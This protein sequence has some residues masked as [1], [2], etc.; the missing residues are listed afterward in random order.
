MSRRHASR[1]RE[2]E[3]DFERVVHNERAK[4][5]ARC[6]AEHYRRS[7]APLA[8][9]RPERLL[10]VGPA[11]SGRRTLA[12]ETALACGVRAV[13]VEARAFGPSIF[14][15]LGRHF[16]LLPGPEDDVQWNAIVLQ[17]L[18]QLG[19]GSPDAERAKAWIARWLAGTFFDGRRGQLCSRDVLT[20]ATIDLERWLPAVRAR[21][22]REGAGKTSEVRAQLDLADLRALVGPAELALAGLGDLFDGSSERSFER[23]IGMERP[24]ARHLRTMID[25]DLRVSPLWSLHVSAMAGRRR[26]VVR[27]EARE[28]LLEAARRLGGGV[29]GLERAVKLHTDGLDRTRLRKDA[30]Q[31][32][33]VVLGLHP[34]G[35]GLE[36]SIEP[37]PVHAL[38]SERP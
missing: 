19:D 24:L 26:F 33:R 6:F 11:S 10:I 22:V 28:F 8:G 15:I 34:E 7:G 2:S 9:L 17:H 5:A 23:V 36:L 25:G 3:P 35:I 31:S 20:I 16:S 21:L 27:P 37:D 38:G 29:P 13:R 1:Q 18:E 4:H 14:P 30:Q 32:E 12:R